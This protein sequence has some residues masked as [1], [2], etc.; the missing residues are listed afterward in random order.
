[1]TAAPKKKKSS[2]AHDPRVEAA[3]KRLQES[4]DQADALEAIREIVTNLL[5]C[6]EIG[7]F[8]IVHENDHTKN[9]LLW[10]FGIDP[11][12]H[13]TLS[14]FEQAALQR[15]LQGE[16]HIAQVG[17]E[18][19]GSHEN[20]PIRAFVP[21]R[22][23]GRTV[24]VLIMLKLLPQKLGFDEADINLVDVLSNEAG[25]ALYEGRTRMREDSEARG[26]RG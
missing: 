25:R 2:Q 9:G 18:A 26:G 15:V 20:P 6:E 17:H 4:I 1:M 8:T 14:A 22:H 16:L 11:Q 23:N 7:L 13:G 5:G 21:I 10:S 3:R 24:A 12:K 19:H